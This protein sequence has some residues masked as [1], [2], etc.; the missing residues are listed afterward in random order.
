MP[1]RYY[2]GW[3][4]MENEWPFKVVKVSEKPLLIGAE[5]CCGGDVVAQQCPHYK[6]NVVFP[7]GI[8]RGKDGWLV[9]VGVNDAKCAIVRVLD[10]M[11]VA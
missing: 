10:S 9:S 7:A 6:G 5:Q 4:L 2:A 8:M 11:L 3:C 1:H